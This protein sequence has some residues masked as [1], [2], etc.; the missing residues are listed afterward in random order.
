MRKSKLRKSTR[1]IKLKEKIQGA[2]HQKPSA[3]VKKNIIKEDEMKAAFQV[4]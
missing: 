1:V 4:S 3:Q 2:T